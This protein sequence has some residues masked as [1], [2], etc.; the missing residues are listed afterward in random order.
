[1]CD[2]E[3]SLKF[4]DLSAIVTEEGGSPHTINLCTICCHSRR[5][6]Q[7]EDRVSSVVWKE[8]DHAPNFSRQVVGCLEDRCF[9]S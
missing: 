7:G 8:I 1:M 5:V 6:E 9:S 3:E 4:Y 2:K